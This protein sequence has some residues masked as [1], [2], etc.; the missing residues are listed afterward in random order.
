M[1]ISDVIELY[2]DYCIY[3]LNI[4]IIMMKQKYTNIYK[5]DAVKMKKNQINLH[6]N[7]NEQIY[8][9]CNISLKF[10]F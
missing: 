9:D 6:T 1:L 4:K 10:R 5:V 8:E 2:I 7:N 3:E